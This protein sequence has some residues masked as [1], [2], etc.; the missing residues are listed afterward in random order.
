MDFTIE[1]SPEA[2]ED[3]KE[4][5]D[6]IKKDSPFYAQT[7]VEKIIAASHELKQF[8]LRGRVVPELDQEAFRE[9][10]VYSYRLIYR[11]QNKTVLIV[12][13]IHGSRLLTN[14]ENDFSE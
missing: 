13:I 3:I 6:Y 12:A 2:L 4:I 8:P 11:T 7:V 1:W 14:V 5:H 10:F 9:S